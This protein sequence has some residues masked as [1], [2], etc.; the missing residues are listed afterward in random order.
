MNVRCFPT[1]LQFK[2]KR[3]VYSYGLWRIAPNMI[4]LLFHWRISLPLVLFVFF[5]SPIHWLPLNP[6]K[7]SLPLNCIHKYS[8]ETTGNYFL[9]IWWFLFFLFTSCRCLNILKSK[10]TWQLC[11]LWRLKFVTKKKHHLIMFYYHYV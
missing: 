5:H 4:L 1:K 6:L 8:P 9:F 10:C 2:W 11:A 3:F 7:L